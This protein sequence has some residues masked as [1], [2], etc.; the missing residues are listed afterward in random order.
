MGHELKQ[1]LLPQLLPLKERVERRKEWSPAVKFPV[2]KVF[3][4][5]Y[6]GGDLGRWGKALGSSG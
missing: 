5:G 1:C 3:G 6:W 4:T 2:S